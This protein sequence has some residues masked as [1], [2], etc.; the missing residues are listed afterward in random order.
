VVLVDAIALDKA[1][2][3]GG[4]KKR[5]TGEKKKTRTN[6]QV[7]A[8]ISIVLGHKQLGSSAFAVLAKSIIASSIVDTAYDSAVK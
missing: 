5:K 7:D 8:P 4:I 2:S 6:A 3:R 1:C